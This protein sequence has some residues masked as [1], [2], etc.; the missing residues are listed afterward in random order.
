MMQLGSA[1]HDYTKQEFFVAPVAQNSAHWCEPYL[2]PDGAKAIITT[3]SVPVYDNSGKPVAIVDADI[4]LDWLDAI[5]EEGKMYKSTQ[6][7]LVTGSLNLLAGKDNSILG[8]ALD[9][10][11]NDPDRQGN[12]VYTDEKGEKV[13]AR[14]LRHTFDSPAET[15]M[16]VWDTKF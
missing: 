2:D 1:D 10:L 8:V 14:L 3:Y 12:I 15:D 5:M 9:T 16:T 4:S 6:R 11:R 13:A 7:F